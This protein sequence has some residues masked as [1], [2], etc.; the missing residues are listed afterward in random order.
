MD[1]SA[2][3]L[4]LITTITIANHDVLGILID[5]RSYCNL[6]YVKIFTKLDLRNQELKLCEG[7]NFVAFNNSY[8]RPHSLLAILRNSRRG[9]LPH[10]TEDEFPRR[11][12][13]A[14]CNHN[15][16]DEVTQIYEA[17]LKSPLLANVTPEKRHKEACEAICVVYID[18]HEEKASRGDDLGPSI[19]I[20]MKVLRP[21]VDVEFKIVQL[22]DNP[23]QS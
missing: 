13:Q 14:S 5:E 8:P 3:T 19:R 10:P 20:K 7:H 11:L 2:K 22:D 18:I 4:S 12:W 1:G 17:T 23:L 9:G 6:I 15:R 16:P 21:V